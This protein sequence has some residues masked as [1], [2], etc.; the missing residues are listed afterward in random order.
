MYSLSAL[1]L[2]GSAV[3]SAVSLKLGPFVPPFS[4]PPLPPLSWPMILLFIPI[5]SMEPVECWDHKSEVQSF[6]LIPKGPKL[7]VAPQLSSFPL[8]NAHLF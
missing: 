2:N 4:L 6:C 8:T 3:F 7:L 5:T 1:T